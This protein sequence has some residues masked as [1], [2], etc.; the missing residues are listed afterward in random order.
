MK[1]EV[2]LVYMVAGIS[3][4]FEGKIKQFAEVGLDGE[5]L[6]E[7]SIKQAITAGF[8]KIVFIVGNKTEKPFKDKFG[9][10][11][12][13]IPVEYAYQFY[14]LSERDRP[15]GTAQA[16]TTLNGLVKNDFI[17]CN[18]DDIYG[19]SAFDIL[20]RHLEKSDDCATIGYKII[21]N[22]SEKGKNNRALY[23][24]DKNG[25][26]KGISEIFGIE[27]DNLGRAGLKPDDLVGMNIY[28]L[29][30]GI[31]EELSKRFE[32][33]KEKNKGDRKIEFLL[34][35]ELSDIIQKDGLKIKVY[36]AKENSIGLTH[37]EDEEVVRNI[38]GS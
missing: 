15:W 5:S 33:F 20:F 31:I 19:A 29:N 32:I 21:D 2:D 6:I 38:L 22:I 14:D 26:L 8:S 28:A 7:Y 24:Y 4:R 16:V 35:S 18:G 11:F 34:P 25:Y 10:S 3:S 13:G 9:K 36:T 37:P 17:V 1:K 27:K 23:K 30:P 12:N